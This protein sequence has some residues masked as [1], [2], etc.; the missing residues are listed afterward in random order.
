MNSIFTAPFKDVGRNESLPTGPGPAYATSTCTSWP[1]Q[2]WRQPCLSPS[3]NRS[4]HASTSGPVVEQRF[5]VTLLDDQTVPFVLLCCRTTG[6]NQTQDFWRLQ[7]GLLPFSRS[8][9]FTTNWRKSFSMV[10]LYSL[11]TY[12]ARFG[13]S[14]HGT[15]VSVSPGMSLPSCRMISASGDR[16]TGN[17]NMNN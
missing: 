10:R 4:S 1:S 11:W 12:L 13:P 15:V 3:R 16:W 7:L 5:D 2:P 8:R 14:R 6:P 9:R 17:R